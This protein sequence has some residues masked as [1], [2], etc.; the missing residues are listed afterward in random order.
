MC[1]ISYYQSIKISNRH[2]DFSV[3]PKRKIN[4]SPYNHKLYDNNNTCEKDMNKFKPVRT[5]HCHMCGCQLR[6]VN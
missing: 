3:I 4:R 2:A 6:M 1:L 5:S